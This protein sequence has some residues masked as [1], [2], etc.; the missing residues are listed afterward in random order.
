M[1]CAIYHGQRILECGIQVG[2]ASALRLWRGG[3][4]GEESKEGVGS[5]LSLG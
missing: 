1:S 2:R 3:G 4:G 5:E